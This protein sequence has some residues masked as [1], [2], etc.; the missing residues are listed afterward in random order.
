MTPNSTSRYFGR[1]DVAPAAKIV[2]ILLGLAILGYVAGTQGENRPSTPKAVPTVASESGKADARPAIE[3]PDAEWLTHLPPA[4]DEER[5]AADAPRECDLQ[6][7][8]D[9]ACVFN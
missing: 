6:K 1:R 2:A 5:D 3:L 4:T 7:G 9:T 8:I